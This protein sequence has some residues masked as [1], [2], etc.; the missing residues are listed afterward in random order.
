MKNNQTTAAGIVAAHALMTPEDARRIVK[1]GE[2]HRLYVA[3]I[4]DRELYDMCEG[5]YFYYTKRGGRP[6]LWTLADCVAHDLRKF[7]AKQQ[8]AGY[9]DD[10]GGE[11]DAIAAAALL[12]SERCIIEQI[13][14]ALQKLRASVRPAAMW[15]AFRGYVVWIAKDPAPHVG[16]VAGLSWFYISASGSDRSGL[17]AV[18]DLDKYDFTYHLSSSFTPNKECGCSS[19]Y[20]TFAPCD[21]VYLLA[22]DSEFQRAALHRTGKAP[23]IAW[24]FSTVGD[25]IST[26]NG[27][28]FTYK[29]F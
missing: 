1:D 27:I 17:V 24:R 12:I 14:P 2:A 7:A 9:L 4:N 6:T 23:K 19:L 26:G 3:A 20:A 16:G 8:R 25:L 5:S 18:V 21:L 11:S 13:T 15:C 29:P 10:L 28:S 22:D